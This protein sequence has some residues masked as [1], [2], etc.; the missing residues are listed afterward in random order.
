[1][2][3][4]R[5]IYHRIRSRSTTRWRLF[6][7]RRAGTRRFGRLAAWLACRHAPPYHSRAYLAGLVANGFIA[8]TARVAHAAMQRGAH[9]YLGD[10]VNVL[11]SS[12]GGPVVLGNR[13]HL[14]GNVFVETGLGAAIRIGEG[15]H[16][17]PGC[18]LHAY[19]SDLEIGREVE[20]AP[21][22][23]FYTYNHGMA[24]GV[25]IMSQP[26]ESKGGIRVGDFSWI[27]YGAVILQGVTIGEGAVIAAGAVVAGDVPPNAIAAGVPARVV[28]YRDGRP[29]PSKPGVQAH[30]PP[31]LMAATA[32]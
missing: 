20:I 10:G 16:I 1:M 32:S 31:H 24:P 19:L 7:L 30:E 3:F 22:C 6:W 5:P 25:T 29:N 27:G 13:V 2:S 18:H 4:V 21:N 8:P 14:Y 12:G 11:Q 23:G 15:T 17:Q 9:V 26:L 28:R